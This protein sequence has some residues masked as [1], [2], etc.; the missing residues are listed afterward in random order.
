[1]PLA[2]ID[3]RKGK[4]ADYR[5][6][7]GEVIYQAMRA[8]GVPENDRFQIFQEHEPGTLIYD[9]GYLGVDR[10]DDFICIQ[11]TWN[12]GRTLEQKKALYLGIANGLHAAVG[13][14]REDVFI[15]LV[16]VKKEN[17][18]FGNGVAQYVS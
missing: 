17:W 9:A 14:R 15:N 4:T 7:V 8:V 12:E 13:I 18:S 11:I 2:R 1:M 3:L 6:Q 16:E 10:T 5:Q